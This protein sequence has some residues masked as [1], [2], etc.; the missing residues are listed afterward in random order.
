M[1][2]LK[3]P[4]KI[5][6]FFLFSFM[7]VL[8]A[9]EEV[10]QIDLNNADP[11][12]VIEG[13]V[14]DQP[15]PAIVTIRKTTD[16]YNPGTYPA[17]KDAQVTISDD[18]GHAEQLIETS[19]GVYKSSNLQGTPGRTYTLEVI[20]EGKT[21]SAVSYMPQPTKIDS[22]F[23]T[24]NTGGI[25][26]KD[27][28]GYSLTLTFTDTPGIEDFKRLKIYQNG[29]A[30]DGFT[31]YNGRLSDGNKIEY[32][33]IRTTFELNDLITIELISID[34]NTY[35]YYSTLGNAVAT[36]GGN[37]I[38]TKIPANPNSTITGDALG[39]FGALAVSSDSIRI[40]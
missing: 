15:G 1:N 33:H 29:E 18:L 34:E 26:P 36:S 24:K 19:D 22:L 13:I 16:Y 39:Y 14:T 37:K 11:K 23:Y 12:I 8:S 2:T 3:N 20:T 17:V 32:D 7:I 4:K 35:E 38:Q 9:C 21:Y 10:I 30:L 25:R 5:V 31:L 28:E 40:K 27:K 6:L